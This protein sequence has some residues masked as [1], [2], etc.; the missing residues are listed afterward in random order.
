MF[1]I[2][3][4]GVYNL[5]SSDT[6]KV[7]EQK[8]FNLHLPEVDYL[9]HPC[10]KYIAAYVKVIQSVILDRPLWN[11]YFSSVFNYIDVG[12]FKS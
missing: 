2:F 4:D 5:L 7:K 12:Y 3:Q 1:E 10:P 9:Y 6:V 8:L 11:H